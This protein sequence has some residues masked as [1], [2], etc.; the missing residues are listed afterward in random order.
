MMFTHHV[1]VYSWCIINKIQN[2]VKLM[3]YL[4][5]ELCLVKFWGALENIFIMPLIDLVEII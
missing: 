5:L 4:I 2:R 3:S 1:I